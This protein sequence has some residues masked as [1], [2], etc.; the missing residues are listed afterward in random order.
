MALEYKAD[1]LPKTKSAK[2]T[3]NPNPPIGTFAACLLPQM[4]GYTAHF[5][6]DWKYNSHMGE[7]M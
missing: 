1:S 4:A 3:A 5:S 6:L 2:V 7:N